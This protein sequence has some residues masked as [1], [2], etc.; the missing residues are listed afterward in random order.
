MLDQPNRRTGLRHPPGG[1]RPTL[2]LA[3][4]VTHAI[5]TTMIS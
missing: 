2:L 5:I 4:T 1:G 3:Q